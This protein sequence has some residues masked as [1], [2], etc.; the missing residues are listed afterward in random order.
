M[1]QKKNISFQIIKD[2]PTDGHQKAGVGVISL[3]NIAPIIID[4]EDQSAFID[5]GALHAKSDVEKGVKWL[6]DLEEVP[7]SKKYYIVWV[8]V[9]REQEGAVYA[10]VCGC[11]MWIDKPNRKGFKRLPEHVNLLDKALK[12]KVVLE[13]LDEQSK[14]TLKTFLKNHDEAMWNRSSDVL[15]NA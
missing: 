14:E 9:E 15:R 1:E 10:G 7:N 6:K 13:S 5:M 4:V 2:D 12:R 11:P 3:E 8:A